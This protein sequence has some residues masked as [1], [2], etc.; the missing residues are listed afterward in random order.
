MGYSRSIETVRGREGWLGSLMEGLPTAWACNLGTEH[1]VAYQVRECFYIAKLY[2]GTFPG[3]ETAAKHFVVETTPGRVAA[4]E[5]I[6][7]V[8]VTMQL[9]GTEAI[10]KIN[11]VS[12]PTKHI[13][14]EISRVGPKSVMRIAQDWIS[15]G[16]RGILHCPQA[17]LSSEELLKLARWARAENVLVFWNDPMVT[18]RS[19]D[20][21]LAPHAFSE[22]DLN[23]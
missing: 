11:A 21:A 22:E 4:R 12:D 9:N 23:G 16:S 2:P 13:A 14:G 17:G 19:Y 3:L 18:V 1:D 8:P 15:M 6:A 7:K 10:D 20:E 5:R